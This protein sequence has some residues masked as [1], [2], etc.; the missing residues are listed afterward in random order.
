MRRQLVF[1]FPKAKLYLLALSCLA[2]STSNDASGTTGR[3]IS[4]STHV[5]VKDDLR[6]PFTNSLGW[7]VTITTAYLSVGPLYYFSGSPALSGRVRSKSSMH[8]AW[9]NLANWLVPPANAHPGHYIEGAAMGQMLSPTTVDLLAGPVDLADG[10]GV[11]GM[12]NSARFTWQSPAQGPLAPALEGHVLLTQGTA[13][14]GSVAV[15]F[16]ATADSLD[17][18]DGDNLPEVAGCA[19]GASPGASG[20]D[21]SGDGSV[22]LHLVPSVWFD[23]VDFSYVVASTENASKPSE[24]EAMDIAGTLAWQGFIRGVKKG[25][26]YEFT[27]SN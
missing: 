2:C 22:T 10:E 17:V 4:L 5:V 14:Q 6:Q 3:T 1:E 21:M 8:N 16:V 23:Q 11:S 13:R 19:F 12:T 25:T 24:D 15:K 18:L 9:A 27:Y 7:A 20:V 26:A